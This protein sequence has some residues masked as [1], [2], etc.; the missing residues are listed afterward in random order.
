MKPYDK[1]AELQKMQARHNRRALAGLTLRNANGD[2]DTG[3]AGYEEAITTLTFIRQ[4][5]VEQVFYTIAPADFIPVVVGEGAFE[6]NI[7][8][9]LSLNTSG[10]FE[11]GIINQGGNNDRLMS[12]GAAVVPVTI[13]IVNW[14]KS[15]GY[16]IIE[17]EQALRSGSWD[18][19]EQL[20]KARKKNWDLGIQETAFLGL[21]NDSGVKGLLTQD[22]VNVNTSLIGTKI[23]DMSA[24]Q[25]S[26]FV[27][28]LLGAYLSNC[29]Q[30]VMPD[31]FVIPLSDYVGLAAPV[32]SDFPMVSKL[33]YLKK[34]FAEIVPGGVQIM[35]TA[36]N[37]AAQNTSRGINKDRY[38]LYRK[39]EET[40]RMDIPV[41]Y[42][43]TAPNSVNNFQFQ[44]AAYGQFSGTKVYRPLEV[45]YIDKT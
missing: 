23:K 30:T 15:V 21:L 29:N 31:T 37:D 39:N 7:L 27:A 35:G 40:L 25:F 22:D 33:E 36:Y 20:H 6:Q 28:A 1:K 5:V 16:S 41:D 32:S 43:T 2:I 4:Q 34:A 10:K 17:I 3:S 14:A 9:N 26:T 42:T 12:A 8:T 24:S 13:K 44:D 38:V 11:E 19:I 18:Y 45:L